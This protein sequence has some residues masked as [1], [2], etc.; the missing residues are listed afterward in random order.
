[1]WLSKPVYESLPYYY[2]GLGVAALVAG[3]FLDYAY[4]AEGCF[5]AGLIGLVAG[6]VVL[7]K[8]RAYR[9]SRSRLDFDDVK[10]P[11]LDGTDT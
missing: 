2:L 5:V 7:L 1:M 10:P 4:W 11:R 6:A 9:A 3:L 8:R